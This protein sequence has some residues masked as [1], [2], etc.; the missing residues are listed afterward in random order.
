M[1]DVYSRLADALDNLPNSFPRTESGVELEILK[2][3][4]TTAE[5][6]LASTLTK[7][8]ESTKAI[9]K[10]NNLNKE[11]VSDQL[12]DMAKKEMVWTT[13][14]NDEQYY[15]LAPWVVGI[16]E[17]QRDS[18]DHSFAH[19]VEAY[20]QEGGMK[21]LMKPRSSLHRVV[22]AQGSVK[23]EW[24]LPY[25]D[26]KSIIES[27]KVFNVVDCICKK[28][29][30]F[31]G[32]KCSFP[33]HNC[34]NFSSYERPPRPGDVSKEEALALLDETER[35]GLVHTVSN[36]MEGINYVCNC[37]GCC[38]A[39]LRGLAEFGYENSVAV[40]NYYAEVDDSCTGC[41]ICESRC[42]VD[43]MRMVGG[44]AVVTLEKCIGC[45]LCASGCSYNAVE[46]FLKPENERIDP[47]V[48]YGV[49]EENRLQ[50]RGLVL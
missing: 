11:V 33:I 14:K 26:V 45:G 17:A 3:I 37:C 16:Y 36:V 43:A 7:E 6:R 34:L 50:D 19:L 42:Q 25:D 15:R 27:S 46:L 8:F 28:Q 48:N 32:R 23:S 2:R 21:G 18:M 49:W 9:A 1:S 13:T 4:F 24:V 35:I 41:G 44:M 38:C 30:D 22:P 31:V 29:Q 40:A 20:F 47:P 5:A 10:R 39:I 12:K